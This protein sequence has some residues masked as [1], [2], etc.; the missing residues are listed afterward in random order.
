MVDKTQQISAVLSHPVKCHSCTLLY[1]DSDIFC[2]ILD[3][4]IATDAKV[5]IPLKC[6]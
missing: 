2:K 1:Y 5:C 4:L 3:T 6:F